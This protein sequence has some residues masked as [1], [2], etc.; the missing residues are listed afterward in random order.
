MKRTEDTG[1]S[2]TRAK[3]TVGSSALHKI[4]ESAGVPKDVANT[5]TETYIY[6]I[7]GAVLTIH[8]KVAEVGVD[9]TDIVTLLPVSGIL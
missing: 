6:H 3:D 5:L 8:T 1:V 7:L 9:T 4:I 2:L